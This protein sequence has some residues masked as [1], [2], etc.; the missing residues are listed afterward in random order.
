MPAAVSSVAF[1]PLMSF[2]KSNSKSLHTSKPFNSVS[3]LIRSKFSSQ[4]YGF[5][6]LKP[7]VSAAV[8]A[9]PNKRMASATSTL[10]KTLL[11]FL[12]KICTSH[13]LLFTDSAVSVFDFCLTIIKQLHILSSLDLS[14]IS[15]RRYWLRANVLTYFFCVFSYNYEFLL[16]HS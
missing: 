12:L 9:T 13:F 14:N 5:E 1:T 6:V 8:T 10:F 11:D 3:F 15:K 7:F 16:L 2:A 4:P